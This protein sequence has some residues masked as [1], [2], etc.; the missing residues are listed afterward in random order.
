M[1]LRAAIPPGGVITSLITDQSQNKPTFDFYNGFLAVIYDLLVFKGL[2][3]AVMFTKEESRET[4]G[5]P[6]FLGAFFA[7]L[8]FW[9]MCATVDNLSE[10]FYQVFVRS[11]TALFNFL[12]LVD[13]SVAALFAFCVLAESTG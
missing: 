5:F 7:S 1:E 9:F 11:K 13:L 2:E 10:D 3:A 8:H 6:L 4:V 12:V